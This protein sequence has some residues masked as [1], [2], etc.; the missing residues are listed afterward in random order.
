MSNLA[1]GHKLS[2]FSRAVGGLMLLALAA[3]CDSPHQPSQQ[4]LEI[5]GTSTVAPEQTTEVKAFLV[6]LTGTRQDVT[7]RVTWTTSDPAVLSVSSGG[8]VTGTAVGEATLGATL[9]GQSA[10]MTVIVV[11]PGTFKL[12]GIVRGSQSSIPVAGARVE[13]ITPSGDVLASQ[14]TGQDGFRFFGV[15][16]RA[17]LRISRRAYRSYETEIDIQGHLTHHV[18]L[19]E[20]LSGDYTAT[21][22]TSSRCWSDLPPDARARTYDA[23][24]VQLNDSVTVTLRGIFQEIVTTFTGTLGATNDLVFDL[25]FEDSWPPAPFI[26]FSASGRVTVAMVET[27]LAGFLEGETEAVVRDEGGRGS[28][29]ITCTAPDHAVMFSR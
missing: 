28:R 3:S 21:V 20:M 9:D 26:D 12:A 29:V 8:R 16:G 22:S 27:G 15:A 17:R 1:N 19:F 7:A 25:N 4:R 14:T 2:I 23:T 6:T 11:P 5:V 18:T 10:S 24:V 13:L